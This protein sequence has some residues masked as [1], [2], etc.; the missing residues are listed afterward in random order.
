MYKKMQT[1][2]NPNEKEKYWKHRQ[3]QKAKSKARIDGLLKIKQR[4]RN[5]TSCNKRKDQQIY[6][7]VNTPEPITELRP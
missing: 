6:E 4:F 2:Y 1:N 5:R 7:I 3:P